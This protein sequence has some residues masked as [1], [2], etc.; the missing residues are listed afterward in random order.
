VAFTSK[1]KIPPQFAGALREVRK[2][3]R[4]LVEAFGFHGG[5]TFSD[6]RQLYRTA[7]PRLGARANARRGFPTFRP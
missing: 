7:A 1:S 5:A 2:R 3:G 4:N 6:K